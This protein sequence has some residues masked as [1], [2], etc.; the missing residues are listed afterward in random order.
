MENAALGCFGPKCMHE[1]KQYVFVV[2]FTVKEKCH[3]LLVSANC[4]MCTL[5]LE[6]FF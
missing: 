2:Y 1:P 4:S 3:D 5:H 6:L